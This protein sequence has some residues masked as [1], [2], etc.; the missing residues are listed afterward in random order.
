[1]GLVHT[2]ELYQVSSTL[3]LHLPTICKQSTKI[4]LLKQS[5]VKTVNYTVYKMQLGVRRR[6][7]TENNL[8][9]ALALQKP[10]KNVLPDN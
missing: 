4:K 8:G 10:H 3:T 1:M 6:I 7:Y 9:G 5:A 2:E